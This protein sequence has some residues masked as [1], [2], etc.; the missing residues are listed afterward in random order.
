MSSRLTPR[1]LNRT[2]LHRQHLLARAEM[3][4]GAMVR[5]LVGLQAQ[6]TLP[7]YVSLH[8]RLTSFD[9]YDVSRGLEDRSLV[10]LL[11][12]RGTIHLIAA[13][14]ALTLRPRVQPLL[15]RQMR[16]SATYRP[17]CDLDP[18]AFTAAVTTALGAGP[19]TVRAL[20]ESLAATF[21]EAPAAAL[22][23]LARV[24]VP[25]VQLPPRGSWKQSGGV[26]Y[27]RL[28]R[29]L[30][31]PLGDPDPA[32]LVRRY[33]ASFG[34]ATAA[35]VTAWSGVTGLATLVAGMDDLVR[36]H[37]ERGRTLYDVPDGVLVDEDRPAPVRL[38]GTYDNLW[39][40]HAGR[41]R[42]TTPEHRRRWMGANG[43]AAH[44]VFVDGMLEGLWRVVDGRV[45]GE[46]F[47]DCTTEERAGLDEEIVR[48]EALL[49]R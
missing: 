8:A 7:P 42:V 12:M 16:G 6:D 20:G 46:L 14:D 25:L 2:L 10:R 41:D 1:Q 30:G 21:P 29:W 23:G 5:S 38:L 43:G 27:E 4:V 44:T 36:H 18:A 11:T 3:P 37:D 32:A 17:A 47:R 33:L 13:E 24:A 26:V 19:V 49:A 15:E 31:A 35:D 34:P 28:D 45:V 48:V 40:S 9:P 22:S 39:L